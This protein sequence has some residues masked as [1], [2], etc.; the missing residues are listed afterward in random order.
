MTQKSISIPLD[1][2]ERL[3]R[4]KGRDETEGDV[5][6][7]LIRE[8]EQGPGIMD[9]DAFAGILDD[10]GSDEWGTIET[11]LYDRRLQLNHRHVSLDEE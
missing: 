6:A 7:R 8:H 1:I 9:V 5:L 11:I 3:C 2:Y 4:L 10:E